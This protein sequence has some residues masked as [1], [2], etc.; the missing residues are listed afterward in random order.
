MWLLATSWGIPLQP[1]N[2]TTSTHWVKKGSAMLKKVRAQQSQ[3]K[4]MVITLGPGLP[5]DNEKNPYTCLKSNPQTPKKSVG[6]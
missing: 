4:I 5:S 6:R 2:D 1:E 3:L